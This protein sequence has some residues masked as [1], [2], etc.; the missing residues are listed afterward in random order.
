MSKSS[1]EDEHPHPLLNRIANRERAQ[2][3]EAA[4]HA[5]CAA[6][7]HPTSY[8]RD[9]IVLTDL[10]ADLMHYANSI[11]KVS[12]DACARAAQQHYTAECLDR[13]SPRAPSAFHP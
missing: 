6:K 10:L 8:D 7:Q 12:W 3:A 11:A 13:R 9:H 4:V 2:Y 5:Y 1:R